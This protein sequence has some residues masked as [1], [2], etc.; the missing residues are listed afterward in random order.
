M[1][2]KIKRSE[3]RMAR[4]RTEWAELCLER[5]WH[6]V[7]WGGWRP[8]RVLLCHSSLGEL[9]WGFAASS[10]SLM[11]IVRMGVHLDCIVLVLFKHSNIFVLFFLSKTVVKKHIT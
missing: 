10:D 1:E 4:E 7:S 9:S 2:R 5:R 8:G 11:G 3:K 6:I